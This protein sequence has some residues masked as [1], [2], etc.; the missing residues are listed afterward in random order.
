MADRLVVVGGNGAG[1]SAASQARR[2]DPGLEIVVLEA[3]RQTSY[4]NCGFPFVIGGQVDSLDQLV[5]RTPAEARH[6]F[7]IDARIGH[8]VEELDL[9]QGDLEVRDLSRRRSYRLRFD[10]L[11]LA[12]GAKP[13]RPDIPGIDLPH[14]HGIQTF[15]QAEGLVSALDQTRLSGGR[16]GAAAV[17]VGAGYIGLEMAE[18]LCRLGL[19]V[20][21]VTSTP[22]VMPSL[23]SD[24]G[25]LVTKAMRS[26]GIQVQCG[27][28]VEG[29]EEK[30]VVTAQGLVPADLVVLGAGV[31]P[32]VDL[33]D[34]AGIEI[35]P[36]GAIGVNARMHSAV[37]AVWAAGDCAESFHLVSRRAVH[38]ALG[39]VANKQGKVAGTNLGGGYATFPGVLG[40]AV[41]G[42]CEVEVARTGLNSTEAAEAGL[43]WA[44][45]AVKSTLRPGYMPDPGS[46]TIKMLAE[47]RTGRLLG[48]QIVG[49]KG[50]AKRIDT[51][52]VALSTGMSGE[53]LAGVDMSYS[54]HVSPLW[55]PVLIA[56]RRVAEAAGRA[57]N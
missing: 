13:R 31:S 54:P 26:R 48:C 7:N 25:A 50:A 45:A 21:V 41:T 3:G 5:V 2:L 8:R 11:V 52:A 39:T 23:D 55:D 35:G 51:V 6:E 32:D 16:A 20:T 43:A 34:G 15:A 14:V 22:E 38:V 56:A 30:A 10:Q 1:M 44:E 17:V 46:I 9:A 19:R 57:S 53:E 28:E 37:D 27:T 12:T 18:A 4:S 47:R 29:I 33:A 49:S 24:V 42:I 40:T 36:S